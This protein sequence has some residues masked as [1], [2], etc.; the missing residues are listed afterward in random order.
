MALRNFVKLLYFYISPNPFPNK[1]YVN[2]SVDVSRSDATCFFFSNLY[3]IG[4][5]MNTSNIRKEFSF[6]SDK[7]F[8]H[9]KIKSF[10]AFL[11]H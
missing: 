9:F 4:N 1:F 6:I 8:S 11:F 3:F 5:L 2:V 10:K 7:I